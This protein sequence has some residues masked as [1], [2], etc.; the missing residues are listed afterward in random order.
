MVFAGCGQ[1]YSEAE[2]CQ[3]CDCTM[4]GTEAFQAV[5]A[6]RSLGFLKTNKY[7]LS[8]KDLTTLLL[9]GLYPIVY[10]ELQPIDQTFGTHAMVILSIDEVIIHALDPM[11][12]ERS[13]ER[14][15][16]ETGWAL[17]KGLTIVVD[18]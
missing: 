16:F 4:F 8:L 11:I 6:A 15:A 2:L 9:D 13:L 17:T 7:N 1:Y 18:R 12:G 10:V 14:S 3:R 5:E